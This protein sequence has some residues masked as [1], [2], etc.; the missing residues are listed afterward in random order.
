[1][2]EEL[3]SNK[4]ELKRMPLGIKGLDENM[5]GGVPLGS[6]ILVTGASGTMKSSVCFNSIYNEASKGK[7][8]LYISLE[9]S[10]VSL[11]NQM[12]NMGFDFQ[13]VDVTIIGSDPS[14]I[15]KKVKEVKKSKKGHIILS[16]LGS[17]RASIKSK[18]A[19]TADWWNIISKIVKTMKEDTEISS[20]VLDSLNSLYVLSDFKNPR[21]KIFHIFNFFK[22]LGIT[23]FLIS[24]M[25]KDG[26]KYSEY[27]VEDFLADGVIVIQLVERNRKVTREINITKMRGTDVNVDVFTLEYSKGG[28]QALYG[29]K[30]PLL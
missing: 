30:M 22:Q 8:V 27:E 2:A 20:V 11:L 16:D 24:E 4:E 10:Y 13:K 23:S 28:F 7:N 1:M 14:I 3:I 19:P 6:N 26:S 29:G 12:I 15:K 18:E 9:Q 25:P 21:N 5:Q 17:L